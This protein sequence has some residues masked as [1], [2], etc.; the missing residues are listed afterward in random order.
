MYM[1]IL[2]LLS[3]FRRQNRIL[4]SKCSFSFFWFSSSSF[5]QK[6]HYVK[7]LFHVQS[8]HAYADNTFYHPTCT[9]FDVT[10]G[11]KRLFYSHP[12]QIW[13]FFHFDFF[14][15]PLRLN[16]DVYSFCFKSISCMHIPRANFRPL[17][18]LPGLFSRVTW[19]SNPV[20]DLQI[21]FFHFWICFHPICA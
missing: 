2:T 21:P 19:R 13:H 18:A 7:L 8:M 5:A 1:Q 20:F 9:N 11:A 17:D 15:A 4:I 10:R 16:C 14:A 3:T 6:L 12:T